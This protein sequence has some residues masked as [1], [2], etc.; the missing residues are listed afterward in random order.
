MKRKRNINAEVVTHGAGG[1]EAGGLPE[2]PKSLF[3][4][5]NVMKS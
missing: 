5:I 4:E 1:L 2:N 3:V